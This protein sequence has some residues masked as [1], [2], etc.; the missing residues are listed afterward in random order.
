MG[1]QPTR[2]HLP[3]WDES[4]ASFYAMLDAMFRITPPSALIVDEAPL[5]VA[6]M[7]FCLARRIRVPDDLSLICTDADS[8]FAWCQPSVA[9]IA[10]DS[11]PVV[12]RVLQWAENISR[13]KDD[14]RQTFA[15]AKFMPGGTIGSGGR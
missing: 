15:A 12:R 2:Y 14:V 9:H 4:T 6:V 1:I 3:D 8:A 10:W 7:Q 5:F 13:G 11:H